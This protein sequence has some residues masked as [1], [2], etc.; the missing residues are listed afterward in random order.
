MVNTRPDLVYFVGYV[1]RFLEAPREEHLVAVKR[2]LRYVAGTRGWGVRDCARRGKEKLELVGY[3]DSDMAG[4]VDDRKSTSEMIYF[5]SGGA[6][7]WQSTKQKVVVLSSCEAEYIVTSMAATQGV[8]LARLMEELIG[9]DGDLPMLYMDNKATISL[10]KN[11]V[12]HDWSKH[13]EIRFQYI[14]ECADQ[15]LI[16]I[17]FIQTEE[18]LGDIFTKSLSRVKFEELRS[19]I[20]VQ[21]IR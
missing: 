17:D 2:I 21:I 6:I 16:K 8:L 7:C 13:I 15:G 3:G 20:E 1:S 18:Q 5:L 4:D 9:K 12:L 19:K 10:I 14:Q 11:L